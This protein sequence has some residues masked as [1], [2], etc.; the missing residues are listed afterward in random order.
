MTQA[1]PFEPGRAKTG[2]RVKGS[3]NRLSLAF[4]DAL[5]KE[6]DEFGAEAIRIC[7]IEK[8]IEFIKVVASVLPKELDITH[9]QLEV[10]SDNELITYIE[11]IQFELGGR[12]ERLTS[13]T[14]A[15]ADR[16]P[17]KLL[18]TVREAKTV[19]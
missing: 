7:R 11:H 2:G 10:I 6:F 15:E 8:P 4:V 12:V 19:S 1:P 9:N 5:A 17:I 3:R 18:S 14:D 16:E 13:R